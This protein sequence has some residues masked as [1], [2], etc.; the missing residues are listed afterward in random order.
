MTLE[1]IA[2]W[3]QRKGL[4]LLGTGDCLQA[5][6]VDELE[7]ALIEREPGFF[8]LRE[9]IEE[10]IWQQLPAGLRRSLRFVLSTEVCCAPPPRKEIEG[11]HYLLYF[12]SFDEA[13]RFR[14]KMK[15]HGD[16][17]EGR[18]TFNLNSLQLLES[19]LEQGPH[20][21]LAPAH[22]FNPWFS[23]LGTIGGGYSLDELFG[24]LTLQL[25][26]VETGLTS[27]PATCRRVSSLDRHALFSCSDAHSLEKL[28]REFTVLDIEPSFHAL[29]EAIRVGLPDRVLR[30]V[31]FPLMQTKYFLNWCGHCQKSF[32]AARC[33]QCSRMLVEG[34]RDRLKKIADRV[35]PL[36]PTERSPPFQE[37]RPL[38]HVASR[39]TGRSPK[40]ETVRRVCHSIVDTL[41]SEIHVLTE[42]PEAS[43]AAL[44][45]L[46]FAR[47]IVE[48]RHASTEHFAP[49][50]STQ[51]T[52]E[53][54]ML[55]LE[56]RA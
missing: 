46:P 32:D 5:D 2:L 28:G 6:W 43:I 15:T 9:E 10:K 18:P 37:L 45:G 19:M 40:S 11:I 33:P 53:Q 34:S 50:A 26:A 39:V 22:V 3:A 20:C 23:A 7:T 1:N 54:S 13:R 4:D 42:A 16:L 55:D 36:Y 31:K 14:E 56:S 21:H 27:T 35:Q 38:A 17:R 12:P 48:Q 51:K 47:A 29:F 41:G 52:T 30:T 25:L 8:A 24:D 49:A 44:A